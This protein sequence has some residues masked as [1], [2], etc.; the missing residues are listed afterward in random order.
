MKTLKTIAV[1]ALA[2]TIAG[3]AVS[4]YAQ[5]ASAPKGEGGKYAWNMGGKGGP[6]GKG[7]RRGAQRFMERFD[8]N[9]DGVVF[10]AEIDEISAK[11]F[12]EADTDNNGS[13]SL[14]EARAQFATRSKDMQV[15]AFQRLDAD[16]DGTVTADEF[17][18][19]T[20]RLFARLDRDDNGV[21]EKQRGKRGE[22]RGHGRRMGWKSQTDS[23]D[24]AGDNDQGRPMRGEGRR[25]QGGDDDRQGPRY[26]MRGGKKQM[27]PMGPHGRP[28]PMRMLFDTF[29]TDNDG[30]ITRAEFDEVRGQLFASADANGSGSFTLEDFSNIWL[31]VNDKHIVRKFQRADEDGDLAISK[32]E[33]AERMKNLV[34]RMDRNGDGVITKADFK[35]GM[36]GRGHHGGRHGGQQRG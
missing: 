4:A 17:N 26:G 20:D 14:D 2:G 16:G 12:A 1:V 6:F 10:Q 22:G 15:R 35:R 32:E 36:K 31:T 7:G 25:W 18:A 11:M 33:H 23:A 34:E 3:T 21:L 8:A 13:I 30:K 29:D 9:N 5:G 27:G 24:D 28:N 19:L